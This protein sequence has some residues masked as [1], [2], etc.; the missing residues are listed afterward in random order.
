VRAG[1]AKTADIQADVATGQAAVTAIAT[2]GA[3]ALTLATKNALVNYFSL[4]STLANQ[5]QAGAES[6][7]TSIEAARTRLAAVGLSVATAG[8]KLKSANDAA[9]VLDTEVG[10]AGPPST[11]L[12]ADIDAIE[13]AVTD[14]STTVGAAISSI[15][16]H[17]DRVLAADCKANLVTV[18]ILAEDAAGF[19]ESPSIGLIQKTQEFLE[20]RKE[21]TQTVAVTSGANY[22]VKGVLTVRLGV[23]V[24]VSEGFAKASVET[25]LDDLLRGRSFGAGLYLSEVYEALR[26]VT[27]LAF[28]NVTIAGH[29]DLSTGLTTT[30][31]LD[32]NG[33]L[34]V[35]DSEV[36]S[37]GTVTI[38][39]EVVS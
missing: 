6:A 19:Y 3:D 31:K 28:A 16:D 35:A 18:P 26:S 39:T 22:L 8:T 29:I 34:V 38:T 25:V 13:A 9:L 14:Q 36:V 33:N 15:K 5:V 23:K 20:A 10:V 17:Q 24:G 7:V 1:R 11:G 12:R 21:V 30:A 4:I 2:G 37:K 32:S 27:G